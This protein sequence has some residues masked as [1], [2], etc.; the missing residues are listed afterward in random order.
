PGVTLSG[1]T[2]YSKHADCTY[3]T[4]VRQE[5][6]ME[7]TTRREQ[8]PVR[9]GR[10][11]VALKSTAQVCVAAVACSLWIGLALPGL[12]LLPGVGDLGNTSVAISLQSA[13]LGIDDTSSSSSVS[14]RAALHALG[15]KPPPQ[16]LPNDLLRL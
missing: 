3:G 13:L 11:R 8:R 4:F 16:L 2:R 10:L 7:Q 1:E 12:Q 6:T 15:L 14:V 9:P 5:R